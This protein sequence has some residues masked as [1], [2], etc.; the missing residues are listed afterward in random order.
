MTDTAPAEILDALPPATHDVLRE[1][2]SGLKT[3]L[4]DCLTALVVYGSAVRGGYREGESDIDI[5]LV[6]KDTSL[7]MLTAAGSPL[8]LA[9]HRGR[10]E[11]LILKTTDVDRASDVFPLFYDDIRQRHVVLAGRDPFAGLRISDHHRRLRIEQELREAQIRMRRAAA[12]ALGDESTLAG[13]VTRKVK[14][15]RGPLHALLLLRGSPGGKKDSP[16]DDRLETVLAAVS[17]TYGIDTEPLLRVQE[18]PAA[19]H[20]ALRKVL[21]AAIEEVDRLE[22]GGEA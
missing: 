22:H 9:R 16:G 13:A 11:A 19:A 14:Q 15:L 20:A 5:V 1:L 7:A 2:T 6:L 4:G 18:N 17:R 12:D 8:M 10:V 3:A 21:D